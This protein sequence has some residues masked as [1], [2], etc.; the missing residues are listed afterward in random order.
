MPEL[1]KER[2]KN[3][4]LKKSWSI[5]LGRSSLCWH[6]LFLLRVNFLSSILIGPGV[7]WSLLQLWDVYPQLES[8]TFGC[9]LGSEEDLEC[10]CAPSLSRVCLCDPMDCSLPSSFVYGISHARTLEWV[11][12]SY[13]MGSF[14]PR[15]RTCVSWICR[16]ILYHLVTWEVQT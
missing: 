15:D 9:H 4:Y 11:A 14:W 8:P 1:K 12:I 10:V 16:Q 3:D 5:V 13:S 2:K 7:K 6:Q